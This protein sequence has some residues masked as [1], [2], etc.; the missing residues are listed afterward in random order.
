MGSF[1]NSLSE[2][3]GSF[4]FASGEKYVGEWKNNKLNGYAIKYYADGSIYQKGIFK[5]GTFVE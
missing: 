2:G 4:I 3:Y 5:D 1:K